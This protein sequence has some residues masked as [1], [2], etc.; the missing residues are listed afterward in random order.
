MGEAPMPRFMLGRDTQATV[1]RSW[2]GRPCTVGKASFAQGRTDRSAE[3]G[4]RSERKPGAA[5]PRDGLHKKNRLL[6][7]TPRGNTEGDSHLERQRLVHPVVV[8]ENLLAVE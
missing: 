1:M 6:L 5:T 8:L 3:A 4:E 2:A 7:A